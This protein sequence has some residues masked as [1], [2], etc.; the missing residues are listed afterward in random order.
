MQF[1]AITFIEVKNALVFLI[2]KFLCISNHIKNN[3]P[4]NVPSKHI[5]YRQLLL[6]TLCKMRLI[7]KND[8]GND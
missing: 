4:R 3:V 1:A 6:R 5:K 2:L 8:K 7:Y